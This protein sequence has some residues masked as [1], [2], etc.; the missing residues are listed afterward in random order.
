MS[1][2]LAPRS[3][4]EQNTFACSASVLAPEG[5]GTNP[6]EV[7]LSNALLRASANLHTNTD[8]LITSAGSLWHHRCGT[9]LH[10][11]CTSGP[12]GKTT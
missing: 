8:R 3:V 10:S 1:A 9:L 5:E 6:T 7:T 12:R 2:A 11:I 4:F